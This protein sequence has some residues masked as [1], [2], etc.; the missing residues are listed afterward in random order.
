[1]KTEILTAFITMVVL[2]DPLGVVPVFVALSSGYDAVHRSRAA[3]QA[4]GV[5]L[6]LIF[7]FALAGRAVLSYLHVSLQALTVAGGLLLALVALEM[8]R[9]DYDDP[10]HAERGNIALVPLG[11]PLI[12]GPGAIVATMVLI[13]GAADGRERLGVAL[14][15]ALA[16]AVLWLTLRLAVPIARLIPASGIHLLTRVMGLLLAGIAVQMVF[17]GTRDWVRIFG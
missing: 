3:L 1:M 15:I 17:T 6:V 2:I 16:L 5:A 7:G 10:A 4:V 14:G 11:T 12:A 9:G 8:L 13:D